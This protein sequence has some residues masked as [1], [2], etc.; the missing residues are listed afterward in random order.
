M[1]T[2]LTKEDA[3][4]VECLHTS[5]DCY[6]IEAANCHADFYATYGFAQPGC[7][8]LLGKIIYT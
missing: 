5:T 3:E 2:K 6:G 8:H 4:Y 1:A 7:M